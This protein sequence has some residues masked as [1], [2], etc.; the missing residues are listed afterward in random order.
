LYNNAHFNNG[1]EA[2]SSTLKIDK[3]K[4]PHTHNKYCVHKHQFSTRDV[5]LDSESVF[6]LMCSWFP[7]RW[8]PSS[9]LLCLPV[10]H[11]LGTLG[12]CHHLPSTH[13]VHS[14]DILTIRFVLN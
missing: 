10:R 12:L 4:I 14:P 9:K 1:E 6:S 3:S 8:N 7:R 13:L 5:L 11:L 2:I